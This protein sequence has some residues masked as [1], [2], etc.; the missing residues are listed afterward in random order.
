MAAHAW[1]RA[2]M[3]VLMMYNVQSLL[4]SGRSDE[5]S[6][7]FAAA[8]ADVVFLQGTRLRAG[9]AEQLAGWQL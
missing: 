2:L 1:R 5:I 8:G 9:A 7:E 3:M 4:P 6:R